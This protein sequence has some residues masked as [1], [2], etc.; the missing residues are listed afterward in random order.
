MNITEAL[1]AVRQARQTL[2]SADATVRCV[3]DM[4]RNRLRAAD[5]SPSVLRAL[6]RELRDFDMTTGHWKDRP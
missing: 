4:A 6:K 2:E 1:D 3:L 5:V